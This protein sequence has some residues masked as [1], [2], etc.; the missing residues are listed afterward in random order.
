MTT[1]YFKIKIIQ[2][3]PTKIVKWV[4]GTGWVLKWYFV[5]D[6]ICPNLSLFGAISNSN[7]RIGS[8][9]LFSVYVAGK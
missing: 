3:L 5:C 4:R 9:V 1:H 2:R 6:V 7:R 8:Y